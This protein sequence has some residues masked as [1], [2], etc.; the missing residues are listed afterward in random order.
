MEMRNTVREL[1]QFVACLLLLVLFLP[2][3]SPTAQEKQTLQ[4]ARRG[5]ESLIAQLPNSSNFPVVATIVEEF[6]DTVDGETCYY[7][8]AYIVVGVHRSSEEA[9]IAY[10]DSLVHQGW[11][12]ER[13]GMGYSMLVRGEH[14]QLIVDVNSPGWIVESNQDYKEAKKNY[15]AFLYVS[16]RYILP[17]RDKC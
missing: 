3:C 5:M 11:K 8:Q 10:V 7:A 6:A 15:P 14:E 1:P 12:V 9:L 17:N 4:Q 2:S 13:E 16:V